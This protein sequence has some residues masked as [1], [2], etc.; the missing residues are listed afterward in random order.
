MADGFPRKRARLSYGRSFHN[1]NVL[2]CTVRQIGI[3]TGPNM[4]CVS[5]FISDGLLDQ[6][7]ERFR[8]IEAVRTKPRQ[9]LPLQWCQLICCH[10][11]DSL[12]I[13]RIQATP[14]RLPSPS[15]VPYPSHCIKTVDDDEIWIPDYLTANQVEPGHLPLHRIE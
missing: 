9:A 1:P 11:I 7:V 12:C 14:R 15:S 10:F 6:K 5:R 3:R 8:S 4:D 13:R 2:R